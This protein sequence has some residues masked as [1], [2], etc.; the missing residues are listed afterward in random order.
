MS[1]RGQAKLFVLS[2]AVDSSPSTSFSPKF[3]KHWALLIESHYKNA[4]NKE[5]IIEGSRNESDS[6]LTVSVSSYE[7]SDR[8]AFEPEGAKRQV[9]HQKEIVFIPGE[10]FPFKFC[11]TF[12]Q[13]SKAYHV[14]EN[15]CQTVLKEFL[16]EVGLQ[17]PLETAKDAT[18]L[19]VQVQ[20]F[21]LI[22]YFFC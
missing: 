4:L 1:E 16:A 7:Q 2:R 9:A 10:N 22:V 12:N 19:A 5:E 20:T 6:H 14:T 18:R 11:E 15:S 21:A 3:T 13:R 8:D 17:T